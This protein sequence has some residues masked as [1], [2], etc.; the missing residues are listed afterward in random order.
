MHLWAGLTSVLLVRA[1]AWGLLE[2]RRGPSGLGAE[3]VRIDLNSAG[4]GELAALPG[5]GPERAQRIVLH[6]VR[7]GPFAAVDELLEVDGIGLETAEG[8]RVHAFAGAVGRR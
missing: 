6:R 1:F 2:G 3:P 7:K 4:V 5:I 8:L